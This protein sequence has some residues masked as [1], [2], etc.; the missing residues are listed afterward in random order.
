MSDHRISYASFE[1]PR[2]E[3]FEWITY[4]YRHF[5]EEAREDFGQWVICNDWADVW[6]AEGSDAKA[7][8]YQAHIDHAMDTFFPL[9]TVRRK[10]T[11]LPWINR[12]VRKRIRRMRV[13]RRE[14]RSDL[15]KFLKNQTDTMI[16][17]RKKKY[18]DMKKRQLTEI[19]TNRSF[20]RLVKAFNTPEKPQTFDVR[21]LRPGATDSQVAEELADYFNRISGKFDPLTAGQV[22]MGPPRTNETLSPHQVSSRIKHFRKPKSMVPGDV[23]PQLM[24]KYCDFFALPLTDLFNE[25]ARSGVWPR[26]WKTEHVTVI[27]KVSTPADFGDLRNISCTLLVSKMMESYVLE[28]VSEEVSV[29]YNQYG[30]I[31]GC[32]ASHMIIKL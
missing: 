15:W 22:P 4:T 21:S 12:A 7:E 25:I 16:K 3:S 14:G 5:T 26:I 11:D 10:S 18:M 32:G 27:P 8:A 2:R 13:Y 31:K 28:W 1:L 29:K 23:F 9:R 30:G 17:E 20:F 19:N 24:T 6:G